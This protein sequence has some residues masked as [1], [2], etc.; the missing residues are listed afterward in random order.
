MNLIAVVV[1]ETLEKK[2][3]RALI[4]VDIQNDFLPGGALAVP[5]GDEVI[6]TA[7]KLIVK[8][9]EKF[10]LILATQDFHP[11]NHKSFSSNNPGSKVGDIGVLGGLPQVMWPDHCVQE[12]RGCD[13]ATTLQ[14]KRVDHVF[15]KG[16]NSDIDS[17][18]GFFDNGQVQSTGLGEFLKKQGIEE[19]VVLGLATDYCVKFTVLDALRLGF[20]TILIEDGV[21]AVNLSLGDGES[22]IK[23][24]KAA[25]AKILN[26]EVFLAE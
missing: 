13:F 15:K 3:K 7:N 20:K 22:A 11:A 8:K 9:D 14:M 4:L 21:R 2:L 17:Y 1:D 25:G 18:S 5:K 23:E 26:S 16:T 19:V 24:M 6:A 10:S 12:T